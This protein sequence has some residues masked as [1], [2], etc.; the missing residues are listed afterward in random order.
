MSESLPLLENSVNHFG[1]LS[2]SEIVSIFI[3]RFKCRYDELEEETGIGEMTGSQRREWLKEQVQTAFSKEHIDILTNKEAIHLLSRFFSIEFGGG[4][5]G[6]EEDHEGWARG[7]VE[8]KGFIEKAKDLLYSKDAFTERYQRFIQIGGVNKGITSEF[9]C[10]FDPKEYGIFYGSSEK[11]LRYFGIEVNDIPKTG[12][13]A[14]E[15]YLAFNY[16]LKKV[17]AEIRKD[18]SFKDADL[19][20]LDYF[21]YEVASLSHWQIAPGGKGR[22]W[23]EFSKNETFGI[24]WE[25]YLK[26]AKVEWF[27]YDK[28]QLLETFESFYPDTTKKAT[29]LIHKFLRKVRIGDL[30]VANRGN[31]S[32]L[33]W[34]IV[35][36]GPQQHPQRNKEDYTVIRN[37]KWLDRAER[38]IPQDFDKKFF[39]TISALSKDQFLQ[40]IESENINGESTIFVSKIA[41][42]NNGWRG[43]DPQGYAERSK[44]GFKFVKEHGFVHEWWNFY[45]FFED[46]YIGQIDF[47]GKK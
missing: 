23:D 16:Q 47:W 31:E 22:Y 7:L 40:L 33:G 39:T 45:P 28:E 6:T 37:I 24:C 34:G 46:K 20:T 14:G 26:D 21:L 5:G 10:Y 38:A 32:V 8:D 15:H 42:S 19:A 13:R 3:D 4:P 44:Y 1:N 2:L 30:I 12:K 35:T 36:S 18:P 41:W 11:A 27:S 9:L 29:D 25:E 17:L 43:F